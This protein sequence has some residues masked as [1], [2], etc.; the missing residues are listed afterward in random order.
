MSTRLS[1]DLETLLAQAELRPLS[2]G[3]MEA[4]LQGRGFALLTM[5][6]AAPFLIPS[7]PGLSTL[8][9]LTLMVIGG[10]LAC[11]LKPWLPQRVLCHKLPPVILGKVL[12]LLLRV[13]RWMERFTRARMP[14]MVEG[15]AMRMLTGLMIVSGGWFL[16]LP[17]L[18]PMINTIPA[19]S[20][21]FL[22]AGLI[23]SD[24]LL[25]LCG[26]LLGIVAWV[27]LAAWLWV[28]KIGVDALL[29]CF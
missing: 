25:V 24:G 5:V 19:L 20:I 23:E 12:R 10:R 15:R 11:G 4:M 16:F 17:P 3:D 9:G 18:I 29:R 2:V 27:Y 28:G 22:A 14:E 1:S 6:L 13:A 26:Y 7:P 8:F 21:L